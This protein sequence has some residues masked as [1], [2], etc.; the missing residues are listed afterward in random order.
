MCRINENKG[1]EVDFPVAYQESRSYKPHSYRYSKDHDRSRLRRVNSGPPARESD[2]NS[3]LPARGI[4]MSSY[5]NRQFSDNFPN[6]IY[7][8]STKKRLPADRDDSNDTYRRAPPQRSNKKHNKKKKSKYYPQHG[9]RAPKENYNERLPEK[10][11][12]RRDHTSSTKFYQDAHISRP[13][14]KSQSESSLCSP[15]HVLNKQDQIS[16]GGVSTHIQRQ[17]NYVEFPR[18]L[19]SDG[20]SRSL[21]RHERNSQVAANGRECSFEKSNFARN[22]H[23]AKFKN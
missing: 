7:R 17:G 4:D 9:M 14:R 20:N 1:R 16:S 5:D 23:R 6:D 15:T 3:G 13:Y 2:M 11:L 18:R 10:F 12:S 19:K 21:A 8:P 22:I